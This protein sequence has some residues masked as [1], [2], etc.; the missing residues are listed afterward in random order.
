[1][2]ISKKSNYR[3][4]LI[5]Y[6]ETIKGMPL[7]W[8]KI[9][10]ATITYNAH[11]IVYEEDIFADFKWWENEKQALISYKKNKCLCSFLLH[12]GKFVIINKNFAQTGDIILMYS[13]PMETVAIVID[14]KV[15][16]IDP[17]EG[18]CLRE[19]K[20]IPENIICF[21][22]EEGKGK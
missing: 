20:M 6:Y 10:C 17:K 21:R 3:H 8:G 18:V 13:K 7:H 9:D 22:R 15:M 4:K 16:V 11:K 14:N 19:I 1:M 5:T 2:T 12:S